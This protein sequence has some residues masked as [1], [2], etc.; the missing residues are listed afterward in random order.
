MS[1]TLTAPEQGLLDRAT[2]AGLQQAVGRLDGSQLLWA[3]GYLAG[4]AAG[5]AG[6]PTV[7]PIGAA[8]ADGPR[9]GRSL[10]LLYGSQT[11]NSRHVAEAAHA[12]AERLQ[13]PVRLHS[14]GDYNPR[15]LRQETLVL[16]VVST[17]GDGEPPED[18][19][20]FFE[21]LRGSAA[22]QLE[23][24]RYAVLALGDSS[25]PH[26]CA[27]GRAL[28]A[29]LAELGATRMHPRVDCDLDFEAAAA[30]WTTAALTRTAELLKPAVPRVAIVESL[31]RTAASPPAPAAEAVAELLLNQRLTG[32]GSGKDVRHLEFAID[33]ARLPYTPGDGLAVLPRNPPTL[34]TTLLAQL[35]T[36]GATPVRNP[37][38][39]TRALHLVLS[40]DVELTLLHRPLL[41]ALAAR[42]ASPA[43]RSLLT[44]DAGDA[45]A[46]FMRAHQVI[47]L[48]EDLR[49]PLAPQELISLLR[50]L[51][52]RTYS[53]ASSRA[54]TPDEAHLLV[55]HVN[56]LTPRGARV[57][58]AST[59]L[60]SLA[61]G[62]Q[63]TLHLE[64]NPAFRLPADPQTPIV[65]IGPGTGVAPFR[66]FVAERAAGGAR[67]PSWLFF[68]ERTQ[69]ED[70]L[71]QT[72]WQKALARGE[73]SRMDV[74]FSRDQA[75]KHYVQHRLREQAGT[76]WAWLEDGAVVYVCGDAR[77]MARDVHDA[78][79]DVVR[80][81]SG[82]D[83][84]AAREYLQQLKRDGRYR[85]DVY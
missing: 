73:L 17:Q 83:D 79:I 25:Y 9:P 62:A 57:G 77:H 76:L 61:P 85:R 44:A 33:G 72:E 68:G 31:P 10:T 28:D 65:M 82:R 35:G 43:L 29:R 53:I 64:P 27:A 39:E 14:L 60:A 36:D 84:E 6:A 13:L 7:V 37:R 81:G 3:S 69:R 42:S 66:A 23:S 70:F 52:R 12:A 54:A 18:A 26:F 20:P 38:G 24:L 40:E 15:S 2:L 51:A 30:A 32:R 48:L 8:P 16:F 46:D 63:V 5:R 22:P 56:D 74:A 21:F 50:P 4:L 59:H 34:V 67:G 80:A 58:A 41:E 49:E 75:Q 1:S 55:A 45:L 11:G 19:V 47:D 71:Y 78:L